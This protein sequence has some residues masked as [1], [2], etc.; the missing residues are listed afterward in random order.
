MSQQPRLGTTDEATQLVIDLARITP[1]SYV[2]LTDQIDYLRTCGL[3]ET[4]DEVAAFAR[5]CIEQQIPPAAAARLVIG[6]LAPT[7]PTVADSH[8]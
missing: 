5:L 7:A 2:W 1:Y 4:F 3:W 8:L 6:P